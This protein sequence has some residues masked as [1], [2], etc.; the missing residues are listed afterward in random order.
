M[1]YDPTL[2][3]LLRDIETWITT[4][5]DLISTQIS[6]WVRTGVRSLGDLHLSTL[7][8]LVFSGMGLFVLG[9]LFV[10]CYQWLGLYDQYRARGYAR[11]RAARLAQADMELA[12]FEQPRQTSP[13]YRG[14]YGIAASP[15]EREA[16]AQ[17]LDMQK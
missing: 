12:H 17:E 11:W 16:W 10:W 1:S 6:T 13:E 2:H 4:H 5:I 15:A 8:M 9:G 3:E 14:F 7:V